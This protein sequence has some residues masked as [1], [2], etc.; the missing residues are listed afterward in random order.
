MTKEERK[1][2]RRA[3]V[4]ANYLSS[5]KAHWLHKGGLQY[6]IPT[7]RSRPLLNAVAA[8]SARKRGKRG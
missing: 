5:T 3:T 8:L 7:Y 1:V 4:F 6:L 2:I